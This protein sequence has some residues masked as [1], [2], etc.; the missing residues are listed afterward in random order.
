L[1]V[2]QW[3]PRKNLEATIGWFVEEFKDN[4]DV[5]L[6]V[7]TSF[8]N[9][10]NVDRELCIERLKNLL[11]SDR[12]KG[13]KCKIYLI[14]GDMTEEEMNGLYQH[15]S[16]KGFINLAHG[17]GFGLP[18]FE[19]AYHK[20]PVIAMGWS[21]QVDFLYAPDKKRKGKKAKKEMIPYFAKVNHEIER[22]HPQ[23]VW[24][25]VIEEHA[26]WAY[27][28]EKS[29]KAALKDVYENHSVYKKTATELN[30]YLRSKFTNENQYKQFADAIWEEEEFDVD[31]WLDSL[32][33]EVFE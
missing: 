16:V 27:P 14:H 19:A 5:G 7:K 25:G 17:E 9:T 2:A 23:A 29:Y 22:V 15:K 4:A 11:K 12:L 6:I 8:A 3:G 10:S 24:K 30:K 21:G 13:S 26:Q 1:T 31:N 32:G 28:I 18:M 33:E 20:V